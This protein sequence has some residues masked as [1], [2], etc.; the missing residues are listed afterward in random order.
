MAALRADGVE[1]V[2]RFVESTATECGCGKLPARAHGGADLGD[3][4]EALLG[5]CIDDFE[6]LVV[7]ELGAVKV[8]EKSL[9]CALLEVVE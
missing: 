2:T 6:G 3:D 9:W 7:E 4:V 1:R 8:A 5:G